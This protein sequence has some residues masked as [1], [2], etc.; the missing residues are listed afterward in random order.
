M[1][2]TAPGPSANPTVSKQA[3]ILGPSSC[4]QWRRFH[5]TVKQWQ[6]VYGRRPGLCRGCE[7]SP[8]VSSIAAHT[9]QPG[10]D[11]PTSFS[12][13]AISWLLFFI[14][15][16]K[17][18]TSVFVVFFV[19]HAV[20]AEQACCWTLSGWLLNCS[21]SVPRLRSVVWWTLAGFWRASS[22]DRQTALRVFPA[23]RRTPSSW[24]SGIRVI[25][26]C[27]GEDTTRIYNVC[28]FF[29]NIR[30]WNGVVPDRCRQLY[31]KGEEWQ[32]FFGHRLY[33]TLTCE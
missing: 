27:W 8:Q 22:R 7:H 9:A 13:S 17:I 4:Q 23:R 15:L 31:K 29:F 3:P 2:T 19:A 6:N 32:C 20:L 21:S 1:L 11:P 26:V 24:D 28:V 18:N 25:I 14:P 33:S 10:T 5:S 16:V 30:L 12:V